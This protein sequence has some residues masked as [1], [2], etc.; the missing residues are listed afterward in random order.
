MLAV[1]KAGTRDVCPERSD[2]PEL[3]VAAV[4]GECW[5]VRGLPGRITVVEGGMWIWATP[6]RSDEGKEGG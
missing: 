3:T 4:T 5:R 2:L 6:W 1:V